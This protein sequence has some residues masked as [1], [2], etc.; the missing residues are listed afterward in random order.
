MGKTTVRN[1]SR[2]AF[3]L[4]ELLV[5]I[6]IIA[7]LAAILFPVF[8][9]ARE[10][11]RQ[12]SCLSN[13]K[14][15]GLGFMQYSQDYDEGLPAWNEKLGQATPGAESATASGTLGEDKAP[16]YWP[17]RL[18]P[19]IK[20][21]NPTARDLNGV[22]ACPSIGSQGEATN[23]PSWAGG[24]AAD[25]YGYNIFVSQVDP[26]IALSLAGA[27]RIYRYPT[28]VEMP[29]P[30]SQILVLETGYDGRNRPPHE[31][32]YWD[33]KYGPGRLTN[34]TTFTNEMPERHAGGSNYVFADGHAKWHKRE[35]MFPSGPASTATR[36]AAYRSEARYFAYSQEERDKYTA[37]GR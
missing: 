28:L 6:A 7:I 5:V 30:A 18:M 13:L 35:E 4:I 9:Q 8:A 36:K 23:Y 31:F 27:S 15:I 3:T 22:W 2:T 37:L 14:Q 32:A 10:K 20:S 17:S 29:E 33:K 21:G 25:S 16:G 11:A 12:A 19:Y 26:G 1:D 24:G 34:F